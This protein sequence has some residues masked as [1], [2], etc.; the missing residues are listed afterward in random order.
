MKPYVMYFKKS[1]SFLDGNL[2]KYSSSYTNLKKM[3]TSFRS[4]GQ[5]QF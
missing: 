2:I 4:P 3:K 5:F 1:D